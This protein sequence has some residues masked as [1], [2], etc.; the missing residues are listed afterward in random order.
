MH[1][2]QRLNPIDTNQWRFQ[3]D[4]TSLVKYPASHTKDYET[5]EMLLLFTTCTLNRETV[6]N[7]TKKC[8]YICILSYIRIKG[9]GKKKK[10][11]KIQNHSPS[12]S[13]NL[14]FALAGSNRKFGMKGAQ[15]I[16][17]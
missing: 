10:Q 2:P 12:Y 14:L 13:F 6:I 7:L 9:K 1:V 11:H 4:C 8:S 15:Q 16:T 3:H 17:T 5:I